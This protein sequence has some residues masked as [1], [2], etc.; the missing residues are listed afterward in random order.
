MTVAH[1]DVRGE[2][3]GANREGRDDETRKTAVT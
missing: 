1:A 2:R 3:L